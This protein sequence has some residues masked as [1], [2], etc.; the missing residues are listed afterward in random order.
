MS[1]WQLR[2]SRHISHIQSPRN[3]Q[4]DWQDQPARNLSKNAQW[5]IAGLLW[6]MNFWK[7]SHI[8][9][10]KRLKEEKPSVDSLLQPRIWQCKLQQLLNASLFP[11]KITPTPCPEYQNLLFFHLLLCYRRHPENSEHH[12]LAT[13]HRTRAPLLPLRHP[14]SEGWNL[15]RFCGCRI[16]P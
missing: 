10:L 15:W 9:I 8:L 7:S 11:N 4:E 12:T 2:Q 13:Q 14:A 16:I 6:V 1:Q 5:D 3:K